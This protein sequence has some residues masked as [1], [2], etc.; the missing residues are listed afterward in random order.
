MYKKSQFCSKHSTNQTTS[1]HCH[2]RKMIFLNIMSKHQTNNIQSPRC[3]AVCTLQKVSFIPKCSFI[4]YEQL[5]CRYVWGEVVGP[6]SIP[7]KNLTKDKGLDFYGINDE[8]LWCFCNEK[9]TCICTYWNQGFRVTC[10]SVIQ[11]ANRK[12]SAFC[13]WLSAVALTG[14]NYEPKDK[15]RPPHLLQRS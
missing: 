3:I 7:S 14:G 4:F 11:Y 15:H 1:W 6:Q 10:C 8:D 13:T 9:K 12:A 5:V 2:F